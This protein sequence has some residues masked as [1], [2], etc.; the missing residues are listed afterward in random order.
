MSISEPLSYERSEGNIS[1]PTVPGLLL[2][3][4]CQVSG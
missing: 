4:N 3:L 2:E 1:L